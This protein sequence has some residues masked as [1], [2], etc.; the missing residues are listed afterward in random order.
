MNNAAGI[1]NF[2]SDEYLERMK[3][4]LSTYKIPKLAKCPKSQQ[5]V[6]RKRLQHQASTIQSTATNLKN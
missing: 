2:H 1:P 5:K 6:K 3:L 4:F